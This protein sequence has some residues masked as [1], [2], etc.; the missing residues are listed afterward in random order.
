VDA[1]ILTA[2]DKIVSQK[3]YLSRIAVRGTHGGITFVDTKD[4]DWL[5]AAENYV[6]LHVASVCHLVE[7]TMTEIVKRLDPSSF[8]RIHRSVI[9]NAGRVRAIQPATHSEYLLT[10]ASGIQLRS[11]RTY[12]AVM[13]RLVSNTA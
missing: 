2:L 8:I 6:E 5:G 7:I 11:G 1:R 9:V 10:L 4:I 12:K 3:T 13:Q